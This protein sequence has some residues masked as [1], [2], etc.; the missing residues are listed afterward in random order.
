LINRK[1]RKTTTTVDRTKKNSLFLI[2][3][4]IEDL[5]LLDREK[6]NELSPMT[7][8]WNELSC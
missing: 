2:I 4:Q 7:F 1:R 5:K 8:L 6:S 3:I